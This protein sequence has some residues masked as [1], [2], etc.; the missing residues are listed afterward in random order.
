M[1][2]QKLVTFWRILVSAVAGGVISYSLAQ[3]FFDLN[4]R[5]FIDQLFLVL[6]PALAVFVCFLYL[7]PI[8]EKSLAGTFL[9]RAGLF[10]CG[11][12]FLSFSR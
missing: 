2:N 8:L 9:P 11:R 1:T 7:L 3:T 12:S 6:V 4:S 5:A 10:L